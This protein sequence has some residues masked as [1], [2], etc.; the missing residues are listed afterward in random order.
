MVDISTHRIVDMINSRDG[1]EVTK[2][3]ET[4]PNLKVVSRDGS[5]TYNNAITGAH[6]DAIQVSDRFHLLKNLTDYASEYLKKELK[7]KITIP[8]TGSC[9]ETKQEPVNNPQPITA[10]NIS[11]ENRKLTLKEKFEQIEP[12]KAQG[13]CKTQICKSLNMSTRVYDKLCGMTE[14]ELKVYFCTRSETTHEEKVQKKLNLVNEIREIKATGHSI[15]SISRIT[16]LSCSTISGYLD[17]GF[18]PVHASYGQKKAGILIKYIDDIEKCLQQG[19]MGTVI[20]K[21]I[22]E[23]GYTGSSSSVKAYISDWKRHRKQ[24]YSNTVSKDGVIT[25]TIERKDIFNLLYK[26]LAKVKTISENQFI[27]VCREYPHFEVIHRLIWRFRQLLADKNEAS[28]SEW[29]IGA[30]AL[31]ITEIS[32][33]VNGIERDIKAVKNAIIYPYS[34]G[35][36]EASVNKLKLIKRIMY[37]RSHFDT[38][39]LKVLNLEKIRALN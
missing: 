23:K 33:F 21:M 13:M 12:M 36:A 25:E 22:R 39:R 30:Q 27:S 28:L 37:G 38:L 35:L 6:P 9:P 29:L 11:N 32:S 18:S 17:I 3:L 14:D 10:T 16:G 5:I 15:R 19:M 2:W 24:I 26:P 7:P 4:Y 20:E 31:G 34:N 8:K 1:A